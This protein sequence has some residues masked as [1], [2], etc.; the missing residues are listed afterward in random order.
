MDLLTTIEKTPDSIIPLTL[1]KLSTASHDYGLLD[2]VPRH[3]HGL[4]LCIPPL[5]RSLTT[6]LRHHTHFPPD[7]PSPCDPSS[8]QSI[9]RHLFGFAGH[10]GI[11]W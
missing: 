9:E 3:P 5:D 10:Q 8:P 2:D 7:E 6:H 4:R 11:K 1:R